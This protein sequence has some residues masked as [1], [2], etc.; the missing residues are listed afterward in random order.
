MGHL[1]LNS[2]L[3][4]AGGE[5]QDFSR[6]TDVASAAASGDGTAI[7]FPRGRH[8]PEGASGTVAALSTVAAGDPE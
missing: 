7:R 8:E 2:V 1:L 4:G 6:C 5:N 3:R